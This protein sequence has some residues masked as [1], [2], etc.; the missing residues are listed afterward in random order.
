MS[1]PLRKKRVRITKVKAND[2]N[3][4]NNTLIYK[5]ETAN[6]KPERKNI[7]LFLF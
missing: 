5:F 4:E 1:A 2:L 6:P 7:C 3:I